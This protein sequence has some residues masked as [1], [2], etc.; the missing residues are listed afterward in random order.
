MKQIYFVTKN[1]GKFDFIKCILSKFG[2]KVIQIQLESPEPRTDNLQKIVKEKVLFGY[3]RIKKPCIALDAGLYIHSLNGF[4][5]TFVNFVLET[6]GVDGILKLVDGKPRNCE[7]RNCLAYF[8][9][10]SIEP[11]YFEFNIKGTLSKVPRGR[12]KKHSWGKIHSIFIPKGTNR[13][14]A[15]MSSVEYRNLILQRF[16]GLSKKFG[17]YI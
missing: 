4:P 1:Q 14:L 2:V 15:E 9:G 12:I 7:F 5:K 11:L 10:K 16:D 6:I 3:K 8:N 13:T 17:K